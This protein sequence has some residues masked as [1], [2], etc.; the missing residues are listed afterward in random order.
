MDSYKYHITKSKDGTLIVE[1]L[2]EWEFERIAM[3]KDAVVFY[4]E[5][6]VEKPFGLVQ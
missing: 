2:S 5:F 4:G 1:R 3:R 6:I